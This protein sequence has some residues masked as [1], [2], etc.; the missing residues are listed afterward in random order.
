MSQFK[1]TK[2]LYNKMKTITK[3]NKLENEFQT[4]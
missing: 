1:L 4:K 2:T 3:Q